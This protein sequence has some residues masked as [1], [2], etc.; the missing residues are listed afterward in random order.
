[1][2]FTPSATSPETFTY[3]VTDGTTT[4]TATVTVTLGSST[5]VPAPF[6]LKVIRAGMAVYDG[7]STRM[8]N[9]FI[10]VPNQTYAIEYKGDMAEPSWSS[11]GATNTGPTGSFSVLFNKEGNHADDWNGG[12]FFR[13][14]RT[15]Q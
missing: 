7:S 5:N 13:G 10:G 14:V 8:T 12:M 6:E 11:A 1:M 4:N 2:I 15:N 3:A 9:D